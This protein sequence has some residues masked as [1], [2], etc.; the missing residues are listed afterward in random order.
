ML[1]SGRRVACGLVAA[2]A[3]LVA[4][5][6]PILGL[7]G[8]APALFSDPAVGAGIVPSTGESALQS[9]LVLPQ[10]TVPLGS[11]GL[12]T[13]PG[14][15]V[16]Y[17]DLGGSSF[18]SGTFDPA[19]DLY[20][21]TLEGI[22]NV[23]ETLITYNGSSTTSFVP[24]LA[25]CVPGTSQCVS[26]YGTDLVATNATTGLPQYW[27]FVID[28]TARFYDPTTEASWA[29]Y[30]SDVMFSLARTLAFADLPGF[31]A[32]EGFVFA[33]ALLPNGSSTWD[34]GIHSPANNTPQNIL[35]SMFVNSSIYCPSVAIDHGNGC[36]TFD[37]QGEG[38]D[39]PFFLQ[40]MALGWGASVLPCGWASA[41]GAGVPGFSNTSAPSGDG[42]CLLPGSANTTDF[43]T[44]QNYLA[45]TPAT[46]WDS[47]E[48]L[49]Y[50][51]PSPQPALQ[52][53]MVGSGPYFLVRV[54]SS[55]GYTLQANPDYAQPQGCSGALP[56]SYAAGFCY[57]SPGRYVANVDVHWEPDSAPGISAFYAGTADF[58]SFQPPDTS[59]FE[60]LVTEGRAR[61]LA[62][63]S[64]SL[65]SMNFDLNFNASG[66]P[67]LDPSGL[68]NVPGDF[69]S[70]VGV[71]QFLLNAYPY[72]LTERTAWTTDGI[73]FGVQS[74]GPVPDGMT[75]YYP[76][77]VTFPFE[78]NGGNPI[79]DP[80]VPGSA[81]WWWAEMQN[82]SSPYYDSELVGC[83]PTSPCRFPVTYTDE[84]AL[85]G[86]TGTALDEYVGEVSN[87][88]GGALAPYVVDVPANQ[89]YGGFE[90]AP[91][92]ALMPEYLQGWAPDYVDPTDYVRAF[93]YSDIAFAQWDAIQPQLSLP[94][95]N[96]ASCG[97]AGTT[98][99]DLVYWAGQSE[100]PDECQ[101][102][103]YATTVAWMEEAA[104]LA[105]GPARA[106]DYNEIVRAL[107]NLALELWMGEPAFL[108]AIAPWI[109]LGSVNTNPMIG[110]INGGEQLWFELR[111]LTQTASGSY[112]VSFEESGLP[113]GT[114][115]NV[116]FNGTTHTSMAPVLTLSVMNGSFN[117]TV[118]AASG[119][120]PEP[121]SGM[122]VVAGGAVVEPISFVAFSGEVS[123]VGSAPSAVALD[124]RDGLVYVANLG[125]NNLTVVNA[126]T[127]AP[128]LT[129][130]PVG[131]QPDALLFDPVNDE[132]YVANE[133]SNTLSAIA[134]HNGSLLGTIDV[135]A[136]PDGLA[137]DPTDGTLFVANYGSGNVTRVNVSTLSVTGTGT[138]VGLGPRGIAYNPSDA[139][140]YVANSESN[141]VTVVNGTTGNISVPSIPLAGSPTAVLADP[142]SASVYVAIPSLN[143]VVVIDGPAG[144]RVV[145]SVPVGTD[146]SFLTYE[147]AR[148]VVAVA[149][150]VQGTLTRINA[151]SNRA[152]PG[153][154]PI[155]STPDGLAY[156]TSAD[157][158]FVSSLT[159]NHLYLAPTPH[160]YTVTFTETGLP[161][162]VL[163]RSGWTADLN[164]TAVHARGTA[165]T[166]VSF[167]VPNGIYTMLIEGPYYYRVSTPSSPEGTV[168][169]NG[170]NVVKPVT[171]IR[172]ATYAITFHE[173]GL[174]VGT[175]WCAAIGSEV[176]STAA[177]VSFR[178]LTPGTYSYTIGSVAGL[179]TEV[180]LGTVSVRASG[181]VTVSPSRLFQV[182][183][184]YA[185]TFTESGLQTGT[186]WTVTAGGQTNT[187]TSE[188]IVLY[189]TNG[190]WGFTV[191]V[192]TGYTRVPAIGYLK[193]AGAPVTKA[194]TFRA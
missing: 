175:T 14:T 123:V 89:F 96:N 189:L 124:T 178:N 98:W 60:S 32:T 49:A 165:G 164:G 157:G 192:V 100:I 12:G 62:A 121:P 182:R 152:V 26:D 20:T 172:G 193:V 22:Q 143:E 11:R 13:H 120:Q 194:I 70:H 119:Y 191:H 186:S 169:V 106:L 29:V 54:N 134:G 176:C 174:H 66:E 180:K 149:N 39:W 46:G 45:T 36:I 136:A 44:F 142:S 67:A 84:S 2:I 187:S 101:G 55:T 42:P 138:A 159:S 8:S 102:V 131:S 69:L 190:T 47:F 78:V 80:S 170:A 5:P 148:H 94:Q 109:D 99:E 93:D 71:R 82:T 40:L 135:G 31:G 114:E 52:W 111:Y 1:S 17:E 103:A 61:V 188:T 151:T 137:L 107:N 90:N 185:V 117:Y 16:A 25:T 133:G 64:L 166:S 144:P 51:Y 125:S 50:S 3:V 7:T 104:G 122:T 127:G 168:T 118:A 30:P 77:N 184:A 83:S 110:G 163:A 173:V 146:P 160:D 10:H 53:N 81:A 68:L 19:I 76:T 21:P 43:P 92:Q 161:A 57:P 105:A 63:P 108:N 28:P 181:P 73:E 15:I 65:Y 167:T 177:S 145:A 41:Q 183:F 147:P 75:G 72:N 154:Q 23:Y 150:F 79:A 126:S 37:V 113:P 9:P 139:N 74:G 56:G 87:L 155:G 156:D 129:S 162:V 130:I 18:L 95:Y 116:T 158:L 115:W 141:S 58:A 97:H 85:P 24:V 59:T 91:G 33:E 48:E 128:F 171:F 6:L 140:V 88:T 153:A 34:G 86:G 38:T 132:V 35:G 4:W 27:T 179:T 112:P